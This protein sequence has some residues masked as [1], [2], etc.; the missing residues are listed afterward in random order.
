[1]KNNP[2][3]FQ[4]ATACHVLNAFR[5]GQRKAGERP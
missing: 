3:D 1:M 4:R 5:N 2:L